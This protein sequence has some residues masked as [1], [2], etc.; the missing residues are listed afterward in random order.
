MV[1]DV[2]ADSWDD[3]GVRSDF[4]DD[5]GR[6]GEVDILVLE[7]IRGRRFDIFFADKSEDYSIKLNVDLYSLDLYIHRVRAV[8]PVFRAFGSTRYVLHDVSECA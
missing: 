3:E 6:G 2:Q 4:L 5:P 8:V 7:S 1:D